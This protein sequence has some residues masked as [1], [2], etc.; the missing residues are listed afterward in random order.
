MVRLF[1]LVLP[2]VALTAFL[3]APIIAQE[4]TE[5]HQGTVVS[6]SGKQLT[7]KDISG[8]EMTH[9]LAPGARVTYNGQERPLTDL[10]PGMQ[11]NV[12]TSAND[13]QK[14]L[15]VEAQ[16]LQP[17]LPP[18]A[19]EAPPAPQPP[20]AGQAPPAAQ[21]PRAD[22]VPP[23][24]K[25][26]PRGQR[27]FLGIFAEAAPGESGQMS[28]FVRQV[29]PGSPAA[30]AGLRPGDVITRVD[31][32]PITSFESLTTALS[33]HKPGD[34]V[35]VQ[36]RRQG[37]EQNE[38]VT[39]G[40]PSAPRPGQATAFLGIQAEPLT[41]DAK[42]R[43]HITSDQGVVV[44]QVVSGTPAA[45]AGLQPGD[46]ITRVDNQPITGLDQLRDAVQRAGAGKEVDLKIERGQQAMDLKARLQGPPAENFPATPRSPERP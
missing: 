12:I 36:V 8:K 15:H 42:N 41:P 33:Q 14:V 32:Q 43:L 17:R 13:P 22:Q 40:Q 24:A 23:A 10:K 21:P 45:T 38:T 37:K 46:V 34:K 26:Q 18:S 30:Q 3:S 44:R 31:N 35:Q 11:I 1:T 19:T 27:P 6:V 5:N 9:T 16:A 25:P 28:V 29:T 2:A 39:L 7:M 20:R 4:K